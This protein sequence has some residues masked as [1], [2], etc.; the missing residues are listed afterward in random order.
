[1][2]IGRLERFVADWDLDRGAKTQKV[3]EPTGKKVAVVGAGPAG[4][5]CAASLAKLGHAVTVFES[6]HELGGVL[7]YGIP[8][9][10]LP[11][12]IV[13]AEVGILEDMGV[14]FVPDAV[15]GKLYTIDELLTE[16][17]YDA[18]F[19]GSG[20]GLPTFLRVPGVNYNGVLSANEFLTRVNLMKGY[21]FP[22]YDTPVKV[23]RKV[24][25]IGAGN[26]AMD[27]ARSALRLG[28]LHAQQT[29]EEPTE[30]HIVYRRSP[31]EV[32]ARA[33]EVHHAKDEGVI[34]DFLTNPVE[35]FGD[36]KGNVCG[37][38]C[39]RMELGEPDASGRRRPVPIPGSEFDMDVDMVIVALGTSPNPLVF[40]NADDLERTR[41]GTVKVVDE[42]TG[43][44]TKN[45]V[46]AGGDVVTGSATVI[47]AMG[48]GK[49]AA[50]DMHKFLMNGG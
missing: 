45:R 36:E 30:V 21:K 12:D 10:R 32:P 26:V 13:F 42:E 3:A 47:S 49:A 38:R 33:E 20:A 14:D 11:K 5:T 28:Y 39:I 23:G 34:F 19:V 41:W 48:A 50:A 4:L 16:K 25:V 40:R 43:L 18:M 8:E 29:G 1:V 31:V 17:G 9:F 44:T 2:A 27:S 24:A 46:W 35:I 15:I 37:M 22:E 6:L 7:V